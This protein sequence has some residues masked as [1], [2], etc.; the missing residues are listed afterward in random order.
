[1]KHPR[2]AKVITEAL[3]F[4]N[5]YSLQETYCSYNKLKFTNLRIYKSYAT[6]TE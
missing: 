4:S 6:A 2:Q 5:R 3:D 1:M